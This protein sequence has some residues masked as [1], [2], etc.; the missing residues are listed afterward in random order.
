M[1]TMTKEQIAAIVDRRVES[2][3]LGESISIDKM[4]RFLLAGCPHG[5]SDYQCPWYR[6]IVEML[7]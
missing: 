6:R 5:C 4:E 2:V 3:S 1:E 7:A